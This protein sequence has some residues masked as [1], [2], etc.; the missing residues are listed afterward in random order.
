M[1]SETQMKNTVGTRWR[2]ETSPD[3]EVPGITARQYVR[4]VHAGCG[5]GHMPVTMPTGGAWR[6]STLS[7]TQRKT[8]PV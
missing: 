2:L 8:Q 4:L 6:G 1:F 5:A 3:S 7:E